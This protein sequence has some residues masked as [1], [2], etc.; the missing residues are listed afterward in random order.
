MTVISVPDAKTHIGLTVG[1]FDGELQDIIDGCVD[2]IERFIGGPAV[3]RQVTE[4]VV[5]SDWN[6]ALVLNLRP[7]I[8]LVSIAA[9]GIPVS[10]ADAYVSPGRVVR[11]RFGLPFFPLYTSIW[12]VT[13]N[14]GLGS[15]APTAVKM[16]TK[17]MVKDIWTTRRGPTSRRGGSANSERTGANAPATSGY[18]FSIPDRAMALL[19]SYSPE[20]GWA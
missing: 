20:S 2:A 3:T 15:D 11:R 18:D 4:D 6:R 8:S 16:A 17:I 1:T 12:T 14:A 7:F 9:D 13:Y 10:F 5:A 19:T